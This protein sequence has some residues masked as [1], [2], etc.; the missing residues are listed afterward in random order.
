MSDKMTLFTETSIDSCH[1]LVGYNGKCSNLHG[2]TWLLQVWVQGDDDDKDQVG[3]LYDFGNIKKI[4]EL[5]DHKKINDVI[6]DVNPTAEN[7]TRWI[8]KELRK[9]YPY[10]HFR[11]RL[12]ETAVLKHTFCQRQTEGFDGSLV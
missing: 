12:Y 3:I 7:I 10:L 11:V 6:P 9:D 1:E 5:L 8:L 4:Q 2:H